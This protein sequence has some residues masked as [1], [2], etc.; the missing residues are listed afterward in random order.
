MRVLD[1]GCGTG[2][3]SAAACDVMDNSGFIV[4]I[5]PSSGMLEQAESRVPEIKIQRGSAANTGQENSMY[6]FLMMGYALRHVEGLDLAFT[7]FFRVMKPGAR[8]CILELTKPD[9]SIRGKFLRFCLKYVWPILTLLKTRSNS[10]RKM[11]SY[12]WETID[13]VV[14]PETVKE[15]LRES[16][17]R[18]VRRKLRYGICSEYVGYK[19]QN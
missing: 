8:F 18:G 16:G 14:P 7:E 17:F 13:A 5:D 2:L 6:D 9:R 4:A 10:A 3:M 11:M 12:Y 19:P 1:I 15:A